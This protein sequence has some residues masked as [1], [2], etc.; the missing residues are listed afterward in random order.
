M[1]QEEF[2]RLFETFGT[3]A[4]RLQTLSKYV[5]EGEET[6]VQAFIRGDP[7][8]PMTDK[9]WVQMRTEWHELIAASVRAGKHWAMVHVLPKKLTPYLRLA[10][11]WCYVK[12][13]SAGEQ[14]RFLLPTAPE[15][16]R[17]LATQDFWMFDDKTVVVMQYDDN[18]KYL[19]FEHVTDDSKICDYVRIRDLAV[20]HS[21]D[22]PQF[23]A[24]YR[25]G[26]VG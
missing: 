20:E 16:I 18:G 11:E 9:A 19:G 22:L 1:N 24:K 4:F 5:V 17:E 13:Y 15:Q 6:V 26:E 8:E 3:S 2:G 7:L 12:D 21:I 23:L 25:R 10:I 14:I